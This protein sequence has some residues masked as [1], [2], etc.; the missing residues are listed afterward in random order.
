MISVATGYS[1]F[2]PPCYVNFGVI[3]QR[4]FEIDQIICLVFFRA[5][6]IGMNI[7]K[8]LKENYY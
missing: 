5:F 4:D 8:L 6:T 2:H 1:R 3:Q 7:R